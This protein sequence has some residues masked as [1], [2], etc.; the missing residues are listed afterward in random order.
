MREVEGSKRSGI[1]ETS[2]DSAGEV[3]IGE[4][5]TAKRENGAEFRGDVAG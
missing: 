4:R 5:K 3:V 1:E 2:W